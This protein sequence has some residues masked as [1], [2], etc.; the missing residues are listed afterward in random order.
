MSANW[1][2][3]RAIAGSSKGRTADSGSAY[4]GSNPSPAAKDA[5]QFLR[6]EAGAG[7]LR[8]GFEDLVSIF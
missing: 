6:T 4:L 8:L 7:R 2:T 3:H 1:R 5:K